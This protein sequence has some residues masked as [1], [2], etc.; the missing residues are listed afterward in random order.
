MAQALLNSLNNLQDSGIYSAN[1]P[2]SNDSEMLNF[3]TILNAETEN[4]EESANL[5]VQTMGSLK[6]ALLQEVET[7]GSIIKDTIE[8]IGAET[9]LDLTLDELSEQLPQT[10]DCTAEVET[11]DTTEI[12][13]ENNTITEDN[14]AVTEDSKTI[15][16]EEPT[17]QKE[18]LENP[19]A[20]LILNAQTQLNQHSS[21]LKEENQT[22]SQNLNS[23][24]KFVSTRNPDTNNLM[25][26][27]EVLTYSD[28]SS[29]TDNTPPSKVQNII[30]DKIAKELNIESVETKTSQNNNQDPSDLMKNQSPE[31][32]GVKA[33]IQGEVKYEEVNIKEVHQTVQNQAKHPLQDVSASRIIEQVAKQMN[34]INSSSKVNIVL[35]PESLGK[36][37]LQLV[38]SKEG[39][40]AMFTVSTQDVKNLLSNGLDGLKETLIS[41]GVNVDNILIKLSEAESEYNP[42]WTDQ[43]GSRGGNKGQQN[44]RQKEDPKAFE[45]MMF[46]MNNKEE[47]V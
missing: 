12:T 44:K 42:D 4:F 40:T 22:M 9:A 37:V 33:V 45:Q 2:V 3:E 6:D 19:T 35:N 46:E 14:D 31:E 5:V 47:I 27:K 15:A 17:M 10:E 25:S 38:N 29:K 28:A 21:M 7:L 24:M 11:K 23:D 20:G 18:I 32:Q 1:L 30:D 16:E 36:V 41:Q 26:E 43:E 39:L 8:E 34:S 13:E